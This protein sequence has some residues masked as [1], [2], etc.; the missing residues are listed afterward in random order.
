MISIGAAMGVAALLG[1][2]YVAT[3]NAVPFLIIGV[4]VDDMVRLR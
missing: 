3:A 1:V 4:G 2:P